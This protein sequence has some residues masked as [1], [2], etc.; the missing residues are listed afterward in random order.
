MRPRG[1]RRRTHRLDLRDRQQCGVGY[2]L[3]FYHA[4]KA[5]TDSL[6]GGHR[7]LTTNRTNAEEPTSTTTRP[8]TQGSPCAGLNVVE[9]RKRESSRE[10]RL[11]RSIVGGPFTGDVPSCPTRRADKWVRGESKGSIQYT[12]FSIQDGRERLC[13]AS[14]K[15]ATY[16]VPRL[17]PRE[18]PTR[19]R[20]SRGPSRRTSLPIRGVGL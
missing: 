11:L 13:R 19:V 9:H 8:I 3:L 14:M 7:N 10:K 17:L 16:D 5:H 6:V 1:P 2:A 4:R 12:V 18:A 20:T 15:P